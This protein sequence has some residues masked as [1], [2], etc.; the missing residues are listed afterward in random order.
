LHHLPLAGAGCGHRWPV[1]GRSGHPRRDPRAGYVA[2]DYI[3]QSI[4]E[5]NAHIVEG[6]AEGLM[7]QFYGTDLTEE[8]INDLVAYTLTLK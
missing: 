6:F 2:A 3:R 4:V 5:P 7:Y 1:A 8:Q